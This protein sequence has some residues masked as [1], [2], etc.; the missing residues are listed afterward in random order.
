MADRVSWWRE[1]TR[2]QWTAFLAAWLGWILDAFDFTVFLLVMPQIAKEFGVQI[3]STA[4]SVSLTLLVRLFGGFVAGALA[5]R[6]GRKLPLMLSLVW[7]AVCDGLVAVA[8]SFTVVLVLRTLFGF[9]MGAEWTAG[10]TLAMESWPARSRALASG[11]L[12]SGYAIGYLV[13]ALVSAQVVPRYGWRA[14]FLLGVVPALL[15]IPIRWAV[16]ESHQAKGAQGR[17]A[18]PVVDRGELTRRLAWA[19]VVLGL[20]FCTY[21]GLANLYPT[22]LQKELLLTPAEVGAPVA[23][24]NVGMLFGTW[25]CGWLG[26]RFGAR[27]AI[28]ALAIGVLPAAPLYVHWVDVPL[29]VGALAA[30]F[31]AGGTSGVTPMLLATL[32]PAHVRARLSGMAY[33]LAALSAAPLTFLQSKLVEL[34]VLTFGG[35]IATAAMVAAGLQVLLV[36][37]YAPEPARGVSEPEP[38]PA[39]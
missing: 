15:A 27:L 38:S 28:V 2:G 21:F 14:L 35:V 4:L 29:A 26:S 1:P 10:T 39:K 5:D 37:A 16:P 13:A 33:H 11:L 31:F 18:E 20:G 3:T 12:Q 19:A 9:G 8:P 7:F 24:F 32:F 6:Y 23:W 25:F 17:V 36:L 34:K 30:G 22:M